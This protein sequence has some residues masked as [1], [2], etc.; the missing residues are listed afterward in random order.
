MKDPGPKMYNARQKRPIKVVIKNLL[1]AQAVQRLF[2]MYTR[3]NSVKQV[4]KKEK[5]K[6]EHRFYLTASICTYFQKQDLTYLAWINSTG[7]STFSFGSLT[8]ISFF[9]F[10]PYKICGMM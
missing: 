3:E 9:A 2:E 5:P 4:N 6:E 8:T 7:K 10:L 1:L